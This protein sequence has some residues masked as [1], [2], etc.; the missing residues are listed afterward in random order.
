VSPRTEAHPDPRTLAA[1]ARGDL[2][3]DELAAVAE[4]VNGCDTCCAVLRDT[5][6]DSLVGLA[7]AAAADT[8]TD[9]G[10]VPP[11][12]LPVDD[13]VPPQLADHPRYRV[14]GQLGAGGM[15]VVYKAHDRIM[16]R[17]V[18]LKV[19]APH[20]IARA[21]ALDRF[22]REVKVAARLNH[23]N[24]VTAYDAGEAGGLHFLVMEYVEGVSLERYVSRKGPLPVVEAAKVARQVAQGLQHAAEMKMVHRDIKPANLMVTR[25]GQVKILDFGLAR[26]ARTATE[27]EAVGP[28]QSPPTAVNQLMGTPDYLS[29]EQARSSPDI[30]I[31][32]DLYSLG[33][34][35]YFLLTGSVPFPHATT[36]IDKLL[37]HTEEQPAAVWKLRPEVPAGLAAVIDKLMAKN[38]ADRFTTPAEAAAALA[39]YAKA[40][41]PHLAAPTAPPAPAPGTVPI[42][43]TVPGAPPPPG[44][45]D[46]VFAF[47]D[48]SDARVPDGPT[49][50]PPARRTAAGRSGW[51][52]Q[53]KMLAGFAALGL[54]VG[55]AL[56]V[57][58][59]NK[60]TPPNPDGEKSA[61]K[62]ADPSAKTSP[63]KRAGPPPLNPWRGEG[64]MKVLLV[65]PERGLWFADYRNVKGAVEKLKGTA[66]T[67][68]AG[69]GPAR[70]V[71]HPDNRGPPVPIDVRLT[72]DMDLTEYAAVAFVGYDVSEYVGETPGG[73]AAREVMRRMIEAD[74]FVCGVCTGQRV[75]AETGLLRGRQAAY[76]RE[77]ADAFPTGRSGIAWQ[78][79]G[80]VL[81]GPFVT[82]G[83][84]G[85]ALKFAETLQDAIRKKQRS[86]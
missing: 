35:L 81:S 48:E 52:G 76:N 44:A 56:A 72:A 60:P 68:A 38:R 80:A 10:T 5:P 40:T 66:V 53:R 23:P 17:V 7:R 11:L 73:R 2:P 51:S 49:P 33:A 41:D 4:H 83:G 39:P 78:S 37:A 30:D 22:H 47:T 59:G 61:A 12:A 65:L 71:S 20:L 25:K 18:V 79:D 8:P 21:G 9:Q 84:P 31:R 77:V 28:D 86:G 62:A 1:F 82:A 29:P 34:T 45:A 43:P 70:L 32:S 63:G 69:P 58:S 85:D 14:S 26:F 6:D 55:V 24:I 46:D 54:L 74:R 15:G 57:R 42:P 3:P 64:P 19:M 27:G 50:V 67:A 16:D 36:L 75:L 13:P